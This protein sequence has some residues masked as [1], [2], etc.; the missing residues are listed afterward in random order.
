MQFRRNYTLAKFVRKS[1]IENTI[2]ISTNW[3]TPTRRISSVTSVVKNINRKIIWSE[4]AEESANLQQFSNK[5]CKNICRRHLRSHLENSETRENPDKDAT[6]HK[7]FRC[8]IC[9]K[10]FTRAYALNQHKFEHMNEACTFSCGICSQEHD[11][12]RS[13]MW[14]LPNLLITYKF[15]SF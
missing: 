15:F 6:L 7:N 13:A 11:S 4:F 14:V 9:S 5:I 2:W 3:F 10:A 8:E 1:L 12:R